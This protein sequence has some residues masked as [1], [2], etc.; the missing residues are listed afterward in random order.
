MHKNR[1]E[2]LQER[3]PISGSENAGQYQCCVCLAAS[4]GNQNAALG[5]MVKSVTLDEKS[6]GLVI[7]ELLRLMGISPVS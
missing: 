3:L 2:G 4:F 6:A 7:S 5:V 1:G